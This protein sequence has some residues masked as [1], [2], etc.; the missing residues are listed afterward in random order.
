MRRRMYQVRDL[1]AGV[2]VGPVLLER[3]DAPAVRSFYLAFDDPKSMFAQFPK[4]YEL[5]CL[6]EYDD[7]VGV[8]EPAFSVVASGVDWLK[9]R[10][11]SSESVS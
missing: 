9:E 6:G 8:T 1:V 5:C 2:L 4:D 10:E 11:R 7:E 3:S